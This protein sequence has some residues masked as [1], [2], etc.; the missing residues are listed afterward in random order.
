[1]QKKLA[2]PGFIISSRGGPMKRHCP[3][4]PDVRVKKLPQKRQLQ[5]NRR[6]NKNTTE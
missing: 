6:E 3:H 5:S 2:R 4:N 1:M